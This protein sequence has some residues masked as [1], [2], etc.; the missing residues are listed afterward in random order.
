MPRSSSPA[1]LAKSPGAAGRPQPLGRDA[2]GLG[3]LVD[4][5]REE[6]VEEFVLA[7]EVGVDR[8]LAETRGLGHAL[9]A[10]SLIAAFGEDAI[11]DLQEPGFYLR[12]LLAP[13]PGRKLPAFLVDHLRIPQY[14]L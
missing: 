5:R 10:R 11:G 7:R 6:L 14:L 9:E 12:A 8:P 2:D 3:S 4:F 13:A 1:S